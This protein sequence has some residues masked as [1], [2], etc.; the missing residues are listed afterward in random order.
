MEMADLLLEQWALKWEEAATA[1]AL[2]LAMQAG[3]VRWSALL[4]G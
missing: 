2:V 3:L 1:S 4:G